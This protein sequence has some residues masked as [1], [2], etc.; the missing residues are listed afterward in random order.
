MSGSIVAPP[1]STITPRI[2]RPPAC[3]S[4]FRPTDGLHSPASLTAAGSTVACQAHA[5]TLN[6]LHSR[7]THAAALPRPLA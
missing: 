2:A 6:G 5:G 4:L 1:G 7:R 3:R